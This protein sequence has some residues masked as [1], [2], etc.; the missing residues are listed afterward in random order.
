MFEIKVDSEDGTVELK[1][2]DNIPGAMQEAAVKSVVDLVPL[3]VGKHLKAGSSKIRERSSNAARQAVHDAH[4]SSNRP[5]SSK[6]SACA[7]AS[8]NAAQAARETEVVNEV[9]T[10]SNELLSPVTTRAIKRE[11]DKKMKED[12]KE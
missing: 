11:Y 5:N 6:A 12:E 7:K 9:M 1:R 10:E 4:L 3:G 2:E 8:A